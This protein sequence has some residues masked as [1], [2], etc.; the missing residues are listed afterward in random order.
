MYEKMHDAAGARE[1]RQL[2]LPS[3]FIITFIRERGQ[4]RV[5][6]G[7]AASPAPASLA[8]DYCSNCYT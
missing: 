7:V 6:T 3:I 2:K 5:D 8:P 4:R 1:S